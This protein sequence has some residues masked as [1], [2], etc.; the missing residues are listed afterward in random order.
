MKAHASGKPAIQQMNTQVKRTRSG[1]WTGAAALIVLSLIPLIFGVIRL[2]QLAGGAEITPENARFF[3]SPMPVVIHVAGAAVYALLG[4]IQF[5]TGVRRRMLAW[6]RAVGRFL[7][8]CGLLVGFSALWMTLFYSRPPGTGDLLYAVRLL[9]GTAMVLSIVLGFVAIRRRNVIAHRA[10]MIRGYAI[11]LGAA[12]QMLILIVREIIA[13]PPNEL[14]H[15]L[16][17]GAGW[18]LNLAVAE[19]A[20]RKGPIARVPKPTNAVSRVQ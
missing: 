10:W 20:I 15:A 2:T 6:H 17:M 11:G 18:V 7:V 14:S 12:T 1:S 16:L 5:P 3:A 4:A 8:V 13:G 19:W 9:F